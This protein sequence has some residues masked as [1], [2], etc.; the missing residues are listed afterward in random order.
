MLREIPSALA[1]RV[2]PSSCAVPAASRLPRPHGL[3][4][5]YLSA[6]LAALALHSDEPWWAEFRPFMV[7]RV[8]A[9][10]PWPA[11]HHA[12]RREPLY[13]RR[14]ALV[15]CGCFQPIAALIA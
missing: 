7:T 5:S 9:A 3:L 11:A 2:G 1:T 6:V 14:A 8:L 13:R 4:R 12:R 15:V 10:G